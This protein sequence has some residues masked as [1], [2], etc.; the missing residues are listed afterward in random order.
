MQIRIKK[1]RSADP[2]QLEK[3]KMRK[4]EQRR[5][6]SSSQSGKRNNV[7]VGNGQRAGVVL[8]L[9]CSVGHMVVYI[10]KTHK[11]LQGI[12]L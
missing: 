1:D 8:Y 2:V 5:Y 3:K 9:D 4:T 6:R 12:S 7:R 11:I 10:Y